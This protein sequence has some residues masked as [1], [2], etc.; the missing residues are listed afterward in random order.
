MIRPFLVP[1][2]SEEIPKE[3]KDYLEKTDKPVLDY[4][5]KDEFAEAY[6]TFYNE[7]VL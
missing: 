2:V 6:T 3:L 1:I 4:K 5:E 7:S